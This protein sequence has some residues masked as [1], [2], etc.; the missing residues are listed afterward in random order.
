[1]DRRED[2]VVVGAGVVGLAS[3]LA[4]IEAPAGAGKSAL[5]DQFAARTTD[6]LLIRVSGDD[7][8]SAIAFGVYD[9][10]LA[11]LPVAGG[12][13]GPS[14]GAS[15]DGTSSTDVRGDLQATGD[16]LHDR[17]HGA[18]SGY[19]CVV[20]LVDDDPAVREITAGMLRE[21][22]MRVLEAGSGGAALELLDR[23]VRLDLA[24]MDYAMPGMNGAELAR[25]VRSRR[26]D[27][28]IL[29]G[30]GYAGVADLVDAAEPLI[31]QKPF[32]PEELAEKVVL[33]LDTAQAERR[34]SLV[35][36]A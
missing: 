13:T 10:I 9:Q 23:N 8:E 17:L 11:R 2:V 4:L 21:I 27:V 25:E 7:A 16:T 35:R 26:P 19:R 3:A 33:A 15:D 18:G 30:T 5:L 12:G 22:G 32:T 20:L 28:P 36:Q 31:L 1:M 14:T 6:A 34:E 24:L 29:F